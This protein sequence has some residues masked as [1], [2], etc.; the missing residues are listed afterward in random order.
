MPKHLH[1][2]T[3]GWS[4]KHWKGLYY[5]AGLATAKWLSFYAQT[6]ST[7]EINASFYRLPSPETV[8]K[9][10]K[11]V[12]R[13][14][15]FCPKMSR[16]LTHLKKLNEP[17]EPLE[18]FFGLFEPMKKNM[19]P[20]LVQLPPVLKFNYETADHF[21]HLLATTYRDYE[22]VMEVR[23]NTWLQKDSLDL[24]T[25]YDVGFVIS[26]SGE[27]F[28]YSEMITA[29]N[30]YIRFHG[31]GQLYASSY[32]NEM[33][34]A[35]AKKFRRWIKEGHTIWAYFNNDVNGYAVADAKKLMAIMAKK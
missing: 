18:R 3:S 34:N 9:W 32:S 19:G 8:M 30:I 23:H 4:Y 7:T 35:F 6:F 17:E 1:I 26:Q 29:K 33:L 2:G 28:P 24:M 12:P 14:F 11:Q 31:P 20:V 10:M 25:R 22:F 27:K 13:R 5:P 21:Y 16:Y 15:V